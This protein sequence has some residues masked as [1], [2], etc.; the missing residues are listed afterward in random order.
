MTEVLSYK[1]LEQ[2]IDNGDDVVKV[3][4][5]KFLLACAIAEK[6][7]FESANIDALIGLVMAEKNGYYVKDNPDFTF[8]LLNSKGRTFRK[9]INLTVLSVALRVMQILKDKDVKVSMVKDE[10][11]NLTGMMNITK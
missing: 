8:P 1:P 10:N 2:A 4:S 3:T 9:P 11:G 5:V 6:C 7:D